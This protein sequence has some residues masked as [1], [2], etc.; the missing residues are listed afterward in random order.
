ML[1][2]AKSTKRYDWRLTYNCPELATAPELIPEDKSELSPEDK[3][4]RLTILLGYL[5]L[6]DFVDEFAK[7]EMGCGFINLISI[8]INYT[9]AAIKKTKASKTQHRYISTMSS[10]LHICYISKDHVG[11]FVAITPNEF[12]WQNVFF[13]IFLAPN[14]NPT[15]L[16][17]K[18]YT[19]GGCDWH[20][21]DIKSRLSFGLVLNLGGKDIIISG[22]TFS[23][24]SSP[25]LL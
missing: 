5:F 2:R 7:Q 18:C 10:F 17:T 6:V 22:A 15:C 4:L 20:M 13:S 25:K 24:V 8:G 14:H 9:L 12:G 3:T 16:S 11:Y 19:A 23:L 21:I 1:S